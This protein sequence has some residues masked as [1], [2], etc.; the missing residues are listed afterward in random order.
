MFALRVL[1]LARPSSIPLRQSFASTSAGST[2]GAF[3]KEGDNVRATRP[4]RSVPKDIETYRSRLLFQSRKRGIK[5]IDLIFSTFAAKHLRDMSMD[6]LKEYDAILND[7]DNEWDMFY[8]LVKQKPLPEYLQK[9]SVMHKLIK[10]TSN[11]EK[12][13]RIVMPDL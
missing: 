3:E 7:H 10:H 9:N 1:R 2:T 8:W 4:Q 12:E 5:E 6:D 11:E 13:L